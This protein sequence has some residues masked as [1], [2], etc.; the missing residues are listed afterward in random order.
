MNDIFNFAFAIQILPLLA[1]AAVITVEMTLAGFLLALPTG[2][3][4]VSL[5][6]YAPR[7]I[8]LGATALIEFLRGT[9]LLAQLFF[10][11]FVFPLWGIRLP[12]TAIGILALGFH[13]GAY[14]SEVY[15][16]G[17][18][19]VGRGQ[20]EAC[21][22]LNLGPLRG[23]FRIILPQAIVPIVPAMGNYLIAL[24]KETPILS[25]IGVAELMQTAKVIGSDT[26]QYT[27]PITLTGVF[28]LVM[29]LISAAGV[30]WLERRVKGGHR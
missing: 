23:F 26:F 16:G 30:R 3:L 20:W 28:F 2:L 12:V 8:G 9:P 22:A 21:Q 13:Y 24:F 4:L 19:S 7:P 10:M 29:S 6:L 14:Y 5:R 17:I 15:R 18:E 11:F 27:E 25:A 1:K